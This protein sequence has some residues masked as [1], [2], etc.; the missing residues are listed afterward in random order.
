MY[1]NNAN[2]VMEEASLK[3]SIV[4]CPFLFLMFIFERES[5]QGEEG[6]AEKEE[7]RGSK[8]SS[9]LTGESLM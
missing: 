5:T 3:G 9:V 4:F 6:G 7:D 1:S 2:L 8:A